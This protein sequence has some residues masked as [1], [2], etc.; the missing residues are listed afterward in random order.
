MKF[1]FHRGGFEESMATTIEVSSMAELQ[2]HIHTHWAD[3]VDPPHNIRFEHYIYDPRNGWDTW[4]VMADH[5]SGVTYPVG[6]SDAGSF[7]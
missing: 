5:P 3:R 4:L 2:I 1:R 7:D 6:M